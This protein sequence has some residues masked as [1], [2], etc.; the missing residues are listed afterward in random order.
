M[1]EFFLNIG[2]AVGIDYFSGR[3]ADW[4]TGKSSIWGKFW[5]NHEIVEKKEASSGG[6]LVFAVV[7]GAYLVSQ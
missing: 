5:S 4:W 6:L 1:G 3:D 7:A 2:T